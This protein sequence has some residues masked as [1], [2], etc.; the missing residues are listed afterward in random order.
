MTARDDLHTT[1]VDAEMLHY[2]VM[3]VLGYGS[4]R[5][6]GQDRKLEP[7][8]F[9]EPAFQSLQP[10]LIVPDVMHRDNRLGARQEERQIAYVAGNVVRIGPHPP[11]APGIGEKVPTLPG[12]VL[13]DLDMLFQ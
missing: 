1:V 7:E 10:E 8:P 12:F 3:S 9:V 5:A 4:Y 6:R 13:D 2:S 11:Q